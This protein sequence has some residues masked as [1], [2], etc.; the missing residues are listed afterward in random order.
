[1]KKYV[2]ESGVSVENRR[3]R[4]FLIDLVCGKAHFDRVLEDFSPHLTALIFSCTPPVV[5]MADLE[6]EQIR[7]RQREGIEIA[8]KEGKYKGR[9]PISYDK[10]LFEH[11]YR[12]WKAGDITQQY[13]CKKLRMSR[14]TLARKPVT[15]VIGRNRLAIVI[16]GE[17]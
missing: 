11:L 7:Q 12:Q 4:A 17:N 5:A 1:M 14:S 9:Q 15:S 16:E 13:M 6:R 2:I 3:I 10:Y 8:K